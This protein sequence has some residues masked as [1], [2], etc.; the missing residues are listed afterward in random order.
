MAHEKSE[1]VQRKDGKW[2]NVYGKSVKNAG[3]KLP[4]SGTF[5]TVEAAV[6]AAAVRSKSFNPGGSRYHTHPKPKKE[7]SKLES[8]SKGKALGKDA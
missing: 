4:G 7:G 2:I 3:K 8:K 6:K 1:T 5:D